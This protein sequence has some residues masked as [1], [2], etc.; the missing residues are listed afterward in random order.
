MSVRAWTLRSLVASAELRGV[1]PARLPDIPIEHICEDSRAVRRGSCFVAVRGTHSD[2]HAFI[3][4]AI[5]SG[6]SAIIV[7]RSGAESAAVGAHAAVSA[8]GAPVREPVLVEVDDTRAALSQLAATFWG[9]VEATRSGRLRLIGVTGTNGKSTTC[10]L[11]QSILKAAGHPTALL[12]T[13]RYDLIGEAVAA[14]WTTP[15]A[16]VLCE[17]LAR[18]VRFGATHAVMEVSSHA[19]DQE[20]CDGLTFTAGVFTNLTGDHLD[21]HHDAES[22]LRAKKRLFDCLPG[23]A[24]AVVNGEDSASM[25]LVENC[26]ARLIRYGLQAGALN[27]TARGLGVSTSGTEYQLHLVSGV[28]PVHSALIGRHNVMNTL[29]A[30]ASAEALGASPEQIRAG[31]EAV[32]VVPGRLQRVETNGA[33]FSVLVD[34]AHTDDALVNVLSVLRPLTRGRLIC[35]FGCGG[36]R[37]RTKRPRMA[38]AVERFADIAVLTSDNPRTEDPAAIIEEVRA[39]FGR[40]GEGRACRIEIDVDRRSA[41][42]RALASAAPGD[43]VLIAGKGHEDYQIIGR[44]KF[45]F[46]DV[47]VATAY[48]GH[49]AS[50]ASPSMRRLGTHAT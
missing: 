21:Y 5:A 1:D 25:R 41:I 8:I 24:V 34:Y 39:G 40:P 11:I 47:E 4:H 19:L 36:D 48:V 42:Q 46:D 27:V 49:M 15:P 9:V 16:T 37:D 33:G 45:H 32:R 2:G 50:A 28:T 10:C 22:Y 23:T 44:Q 31:L 3:N 7:S 30:A 13:I 29:A 38:A 6:A 26:A 20:R 43:T 18:A 35:V 17:S 12:G 14:D